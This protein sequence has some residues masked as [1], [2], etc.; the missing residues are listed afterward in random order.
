MEKLPL[1]RKEDECSE[2]HNGFMVTENDLRYD[3]EYSNLHAD[4]W[5]LG[6]E[7]SKEIGIFWTCPD[8]GTMNGFVEQFGLPDRVRHKAGKLFEA[9]KAKSQEGRAL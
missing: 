9:E 5:E 2:C 4:D 6:G 7:L 3:Q 8:C 1:Y